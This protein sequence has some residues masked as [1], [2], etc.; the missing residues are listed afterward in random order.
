MIGWLAN[1]WWLAGNIRSNYEKSVA[2]TF[3]M[4]IN[5]WLSHPK[6]L[7]I[8][9][10]IL[11]TYKRLRNRLLGNKLYFKRRKRRR[12][13]RRKIT[14]RKPIQL[15]LQLYKSI[16]IQKREK[17]GKKE[18]NI[19]ASTA[20]TNTHCHLQRLTVAVA[21]AGIK[22]LTTVCAAWINYGHF[23]SQMEGNFGLLIHNILLVLNN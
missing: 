13:Y 19:V 21:M 1:V 11:I 4:P 17:R 2:Y 20:A 15:F 5:H 7:A 23:R 10:I 3:Q 9:N 16:R 14:E 22:M 18:K 8:N 12:R 6:S